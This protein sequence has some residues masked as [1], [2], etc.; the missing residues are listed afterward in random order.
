MS[1]VSLRPIKEDDL[2]FLQR[3]TDD[4][5]DSSSF[6]RPGFVDPRQWR[7]RWDAGELVGDSG[8]IV[9]IARGD[10][11]AGFVDWSAHQWFGRKCWSLGIQLEPSVRGRGIGTEAHKLIVGY[12]FDRDPVN[13]IEAYTDVDNH[14]ERR[15]LEKAGFTL[16]GTLHGAAFRDGRWHDGVLYSMIRP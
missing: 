6:M 1:E 9:L 5:T 7:R 2:P 3:L 10:E 4:R 15:A 13:R 16:E 14:A 11:R 8:G 12:L